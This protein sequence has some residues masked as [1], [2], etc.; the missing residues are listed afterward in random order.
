MKFACTAVAAVAAVAVV[1]A[2]AA[3]TSALDPVFL[4]LFVEVDDQSR[5]FV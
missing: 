2:V 3:V 4:S 1:A 5:T